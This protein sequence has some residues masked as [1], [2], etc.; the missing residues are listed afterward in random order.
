MTLEQALK[1]IQDKESQVTNLQKEIRET[2]AQLKNLTLCKVGDKVLVNWG[3]NNEECYVANV[4][5]NS[6]HKDLY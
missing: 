5:Y 1:R 3:S 6:Y 4:E 2:K